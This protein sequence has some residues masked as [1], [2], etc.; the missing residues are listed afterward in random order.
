[1]D[2]RKE[3]K[4]LKKIWEA[5]GLPK[6]LLLRMPAL[7]SYMDE[8]LERGSCLTYT[9]LVCAYSSRR[10]ADDVSNCSRF[11]LGTAARHKILRMVG[12]SAVSVPVSSGL[13]WT[14]SFIWPPTTVYRAL[15]L[16]AVPSLDLL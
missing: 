12:R 8:P 1:M 5:A 4:T 10:N 9:L 15:C 2:L 7:Q 16:M 11:R 3:T 14:Y 13:K 6:G